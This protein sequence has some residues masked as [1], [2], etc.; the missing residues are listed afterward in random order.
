MRIS[1]RND[2]NISPPPDCA[3]EGVEKS[4][5]MI[6]IVRVF[7]ISDTLFIFPTTPPHFQEAQQSSGRWL[8][9]GF[10]YGKFRTEYLGR[11][12]WNVV[13]VEFYSTSFEFLTDAFT[14]EFLCGFN[15]V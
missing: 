3:K 14:G 15:L 13:W 11:T 12:R 8:L 6:P 7:F 2:V 10:S 1:G 5:S 9:S 4:V